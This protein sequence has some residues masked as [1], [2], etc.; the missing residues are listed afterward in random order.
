MDDD[1]FPLVFHEPSL[2]ELQSINEISNVFCT[3]KYWYILSSGKKLFQIGIDSLYLSASSQDIIRPIC[4]I[5]FDSYIKKIDFIN[6][7]KK[8]YIIYLKKK[9]LFLI[10]EDSLNLKNQEPIIDHKNIID[11]C[12]V[13]EENSIRILTP[14]WN[15]RGKCLIQTYLFV[16]EKRLT[17]NSEN[18]IET[19]VT[20]TDKGK[21]ACTFKYALVNF[22]GK[23][24]FYE[25]GQTPIQVNVDGTIDIGL[26]KSTIKT[27]N[28]FYILTKKCLVLISYKADK[29]EISF[30]MPIFKCDIFYPY[31]IVIFKKKIEVIT[32]VG[33]LRK[34][35]HID[36]YNNH[37]YVKVLNDYSF[38]YTVLNKLYFVK[39]ISPV[40]Q[41]DSFVMKYEW[42]NAIELCSLFQNNNEA[43]KYK[44]HELYCL[45][46]KTLLM[47]EMYVEA[48]IN[49]QKCEH[50]PM[51][52]LRNFSSLLPNEIF[53]DS[54]FYKDWKLESKKLSIEKQQSTECVNE[55]IRYLE[56]KLQTQN[57]D[58]NNDLTTTKVINT[59]LI[60]CYFLTQPSQ[61]IPYL[62]SKPLIFIDSTLEFLKNVGNGEEYYIELC[63]IY[64]HEQEAVNY[65]ITL[66][67]IEKLITHIQES[68]DFEKYAKQVFLL[69]YEKD[70]ESS[71]LLFC[72]K[73]LNNSQAFDILEFLEDCI[74][75]DEYK[76]QIQII[77]LIFCVETRQLKESKLIILLINKILFALKDIE[78]FRSKNT[79]KIYVSIENEEHPRI[80]K[81]R[82]ELQKIFEK[83]NHSIA[84][85]Q[86]ER[87]SVCFLEEKLSALRNIGLYDDCISL[88]TNRN[89]DFL[90][91][92]NF[93]EL[94]RI[95]GK[96]DIYTML[97]LKLSKIE[98]D[99]HERLFKLIKMKKQYLDATVVI[100]HLPTG[101]KIYEI[102]DYLKYMTVDI[103][104]EI[105]QTKLE[106]ALTNNTIIH[107]KQELKYL[108]AGSVTITPD[109]ICSTCGN[110]IGMSDFY[111]LENNTI[112]HVACCPPDDAFNL[113]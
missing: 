99:Q 73:F 47:K 84:R 38:L 108:K 110:L 92:I 74:S 2:I 111:V 39:F 17:R 3:D 56:K 67:N 80:K 4:D 85:S 21:L 57:Y 45:Y 98:E 75:N 28:L 81:Y 20:I 30:D 72:S 107:R 50:K 87:I 79:N 42:E 76:N 7:K 27:P 63:K 11:F 68:V 5:Q 93:C 1:N 33:G 83:C 101:V 91:M 106:N 8:T 40:T 12:I 59:M 15:D 46:G 54:T 58:T 52:I 90:I 77:F 18:P 112:V 105:R 23:N 69:V 36:Q 82:A 49:F 103:Q 48:F 96:D 22:N 51:S 37:F 78:E 53:L 109:T 102:L 14:D 13:Q 24:I 9:Q 88:I 113:F 97:Y 32:L 35:F 94:S 65:L 41:I 34:V 31:A 26:V 25:N 19:Q 16:D 55:L 43:L 10:D 61:L 100:Q 89:I 71:A 60:K 44:L 66:G 104:N 95:A 64:E 70:Y 29:V 62:T 6:Y 86:H